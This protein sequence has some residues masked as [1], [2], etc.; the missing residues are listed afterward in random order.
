MIDL[1]GGQAVH[2]TGGC[3]HAYR[4]LDA[5]ADVP[6]NGDPSALAR[7]YRERLGLEELYVADLDAIAGG[8]EQDAAVRAMAS[9]R[10][11]IWLD[12]GSATTAQAR[13]ALA[14]GASHVVVGL[15]TLTSF[16][17]LRDIAHEIGFHC[18]AFSLDLR[19]GQPIA[20]GD[21]SR[22]LPE[23][24]AQRAVAAGATSVIVLDLA[25]VGSGRGLDLSIIERVRR[26]VPG[27]TLLAG[28]GVRDADD[29]RKLASVGCDGALVATALHG[30]GAAAVLRAARGDVHA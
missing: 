4:P 9:Q 28:G 5:A 6:V 19:D 8:N 11:T 12:A 1:L 23:A 20:T 3:R 26:A 15:E 27:T 21:L 30:A 22:M 10:T 29:L 13:R 7:V 16:D 24:I 2:A 25:R 18:V 17:A 14:R